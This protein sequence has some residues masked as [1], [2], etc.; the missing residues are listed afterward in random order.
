MARVRDMQG[1]PAHLEYL[2]SDGK[3]R[4]P[5]YCV[6]HEG[7]GKSRICANPAGPKYRQPCTTAKNCDYYEP[8]IQG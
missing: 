8:G 2:R 7:A 3:R 6:F 1:V 5:S 4:H